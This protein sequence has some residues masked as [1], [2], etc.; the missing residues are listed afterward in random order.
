MLSEPSWWSPGGAMG[1]SQRGEGSGSVCTDVAARPGG[2]VAGLHAWGC[3]GGHV[4]LQA[5]HVRLQA[6]CRQEDVQTP[7][8]SLRHL[9][10]VLH[11]WPAKA[12]LGIDL[13]VI[14]LW[15]NLPD[16][17]LRVLLS[18]IYLAF[19]DKVPMQM[20]LILI[21]LM[22]KEKGGEREVRGR[23]HIPLFPY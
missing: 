10:N 20:L 17:A 5:A 23:N 6:A 2:G 8:F 22:P 9:R 18:I 1:G 7:K 4:R 15:A 21:G 16:E 19:N 13:W 3:K 11:S 14:S 12:G